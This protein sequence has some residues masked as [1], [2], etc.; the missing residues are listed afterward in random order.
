MYYYNLIFRLYSSFINCLHNVLYSKMFQG[1]VLDL[2][3][4]WKL[5]LN[6]S[7]ICHEERPGTFKSSNT[8]IGFCLKVTKSIF[9]C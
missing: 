2:S 3:F 4:A 1:N 6:F 5:S 7:V 9:Y 8:W